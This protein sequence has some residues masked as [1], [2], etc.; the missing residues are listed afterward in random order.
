MNDNLNNLENSLSQEIAALKEKFNRIKTDSEEFVVASKQLSDRGVGEAK[1]LINEA[2]ENW[3][4]IRSAFEGSPVAKL[5]AKAKKAVKKSA[6][7]KSV[8]TAGKKLATKAKSA[9]K[10]S[11]A[12]KAAP[13]SKKKSKK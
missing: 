11:P 7:K 9:A 13:K 1:V 4:A 8:K 3:L 12:K 5:F 6:S 10:K 2:K